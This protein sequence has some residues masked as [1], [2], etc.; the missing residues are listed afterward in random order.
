MFDKKPKISVILPFYNAEKT[1]ERAINSIVNQTYSDFECIL[2]DNNSSD[3]S[4]KIVKR[5]V[6]TDNRFI[7]ISEKQQG[8]MFASNAGWNFSKG[9]YIARMDA[10]DWSYPQRLEKQAGF[11]DDNP[12]FGAVGSLVKHVSHSE[13]TEGMARFVDWSNSLFTEKGIYNNRFV[14]LP[15]VN[16]TAMW[17]RNIAQKHGMY[18]KGDFPEDYEMWLRWF[19]KGV[20]IGKVNEILLDWYDSDTRI[21]RNDNIYRDK[22]FY[23]IKTHY[24]ANWLR[25]NNPFHPKVAIWGASKISRRRAKLLEP[26]GIEISCYIDTK[27]AKRNIDKKVYYYEDIPSPHEVFVLTYIKQKEA[28]EEV[29]E[30]LAAKEFVEGKDYLVIS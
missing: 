16:P 6:D 25:R 3:N 12:D 18:L 30:F 14:E 22:A 15:I 7:A 29:R 9:E 17:R 4:I 21:S 5:I 23:N 1:I 2:I 20:R 19:E 24:L 26:L 27:K 13:Y 10:D 28:R 8:V 11:L